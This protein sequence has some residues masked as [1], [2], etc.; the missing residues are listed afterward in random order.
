MSANENNITAYKAFDSD[1]TCRGY[2]YEVGKTYTH[3]GDVVLCESGFHACEVPFD[4]WQYYVGSMT[5]AK[6]ELSGV[7]PA[8]QGDSKR[9]AASITISASLSLPE[10][11]T[12]QARV[13][14]EL[15]KAAAGKLASG[16]E[17]SSLAEQGHAATTGDD[18]H[19]AAT[20]E[21]GHAAATG[22]RGH[23]AATGYRGHVAVE[24]KNSIAAS[25]GIRGTARAQAGGAIT[26][27]AYDDDGDLVAIRSA[28]VGTD[29]VEPGKTYRLTVDGEFQEVGE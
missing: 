7:D 19:A 26:L 25:L 12:E 15:C 20:G 6:V 17:E 4:C 5:F 14:V 29:G 21:Y 2:Q 23:A 22:F 9:V 24:G 28:L 10:W 1:W 27:A 11:I 16:E 18:G 3:E 8:R 13:V